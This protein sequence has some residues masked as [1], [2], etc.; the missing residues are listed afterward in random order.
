MWHLLSQVAV[1]FFGASCGTAVAA[2]NKMN[3]WETGVVAGGS[4][5]F[6]MVVYSACMN[7]EIDRARRSGEIE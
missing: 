4:V 3:S 2:I 5:V 7:L 1:L 6:F